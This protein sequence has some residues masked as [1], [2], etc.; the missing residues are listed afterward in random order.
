MP[1]ILSSMNGVSLTGDLGGGNGF[2]FSYDVYFGGITL[3]VER[4]WEQLEMGAA[5]VDHQD[6]LER[7]AN[8]VGGRVRLR[9]PIDGL[10]VG[11]SAF[12]GPEAPEH[13]EEE[14][15]GDGL[16]WAAGGHLNLTTGRTLFRA[17]YAH[18]RDNGLGQRGDAAYGELAYRLHPI[19]VVTHV[20]WST[21]QLTDVDI[22]AGAESL[23]D[24][25]ELAGG[26]NYWFGSDLVI[27]SAYH[28]VHGTRFAHTESM[29][30]MQVDAGELS[31]TTHLVEVGV[32]FA[33]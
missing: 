32:D 1:A 7:L 15:E 11:A 28:Y 24:H 23:V 18:V 26:V 10:E 13:G 19:Q 31:P 22:P 29:L 20:E 25:I 16:Y 17:E 12:G 3:E 21:A 2:E 33:F 5:A 14:E 8:T 6:A 9:L 30:A 4:P 27:K